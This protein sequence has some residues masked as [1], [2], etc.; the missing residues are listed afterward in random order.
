MNTTCGIALVPERL[1]EPLKSDQLANNRG[2]IK[3]LLLK[4]NQGSQKVF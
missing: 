3:W 2:K 1:T 4:D